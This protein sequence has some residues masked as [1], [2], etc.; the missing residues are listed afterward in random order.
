MRYIRYDREQF[1]ECPVDGSDGSET[2]FEPEDLEDEEPHPN[3][4]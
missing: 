1:P 4:P 3:R 2:G